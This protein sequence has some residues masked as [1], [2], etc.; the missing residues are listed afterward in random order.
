EAPAESQIARGKNSRRCGHQRCGIDF[1]SSLP[2]RLDAIRRLEERK[3][4]S[5]PNGKNYS[6]TGNDS[7]RG[8]SKLRI[9]AHLLI[10]NG[11][12]ANH[13]EAGEFSVFADKLLRAE[14]GAYFDSLHRALFDLFFG[15][16]H[17]FAGFQANKVYFTS[18]H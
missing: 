2:C 18:T 11:N 3:I 15:C 8:I 7:L 1:Q 4:R 9:E 12:A 5:L 10:K 14:R 6:V 13:F 17:F 16:G